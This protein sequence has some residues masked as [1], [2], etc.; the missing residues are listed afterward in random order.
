MPIAVILLL[1]VLLVVATGNSTP[2]P[3]ESPSA[4]STETS[5]ARTTGSDGSQPQGEEPK[6]AAVLFIPAA[7]RHVSTVE[8]TMSSS[9]KGAKIWYTIDGSDPIPREIGTY[10]YSE[11]EPLYI[12]DIGVTVIKAV[13]TAENLDTNY[14]SRVVWSGKQFFKQKIC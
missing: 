7:E 10:L 4:V 1:L 11:N 13:A 3:T 14:T 9:S 2:F 12:D 6:A 5:T 8:V